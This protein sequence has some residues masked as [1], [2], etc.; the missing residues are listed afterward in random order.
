[1]HLTFVY[2]VKIKKFNRTEFTNK[3]LVMSSMGRSSLA[4]HISII[5]FSKLLNKESI[6]VIIGEKCT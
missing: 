5:C 2:I 6:K 4:C 3:T 1:M